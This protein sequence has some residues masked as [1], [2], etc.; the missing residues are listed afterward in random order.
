MSLIERCPHFR[1]KLYV[2]L[3]FGTAQAVLIIGVLIEGILISGVSLFHV[4]PYRECP[5]FRDPYRV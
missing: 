5:Y 4:C 2:I 1:V 3:M